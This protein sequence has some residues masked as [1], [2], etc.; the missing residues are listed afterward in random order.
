MFAGLVV[1]N[2]QF[3]VLQAVNSIDDHVDVQAVDIDVQALFQGLDRKRAAPGLQIQPFEDQIDQALVFQGGELFS[4][5]P[6]PYAAHVLDSLVHSCADCICTCSSGQAEQ[7]GL[8]LAILPKMFQGGMDDGPPFRR[9][10]TRNRLFQALG[11]QA[12]PG[13][14]LEG[15]GGLGA[16]ETG[17]SGGST[18]RGKGRA[19]NVLKRLQ[20]I[21]RWPLQP[22]VGKRFQMEV[23]WIQF[24]QSVQEGTGQEIPVF[25]PQGTAEDHFRSA[26]FQPGDYFAGIVQFML[27]AGPGH[28]QSALQGSGQEGAGFRC[29]RPGLVGKAHDPQA[30]KAFAYSLQHAHDLN[31]GLR[32]FGLEYCLGQDGM[33]A[34]YSLTV[35]HI[36]ADPVQP[37]QALQAGSESLDGLVLAA[38]QASFSRPAH[39]LKQN[40]QSLGPGTGGLGRGQCSA[41]GGE[42]IQTLDQHG[43]GL[44]AVISII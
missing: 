39:V 40:V 7:G 24:R 23:G 44:E 2:H 26:L 34:V 25:F 36:R 28:A 13:K 17:A 16:K 5:T 3:A 1:D 6:W 11:S 12:V 33:Q 30:V 31:P 41:S 21:F 27:R 37:G 42:G 10:Q 15:A 19:L 18:G 35:G 32:A 38:V 8:V 4:H 22:G 14:G 20:I 29:R 9:T 43:A